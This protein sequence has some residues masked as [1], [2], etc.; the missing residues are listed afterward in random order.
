MDIHVLLDVK[1]YHYNKKLFRHPA[2]N[3]QGLFCS[4]CPT[5]KLKS[6]SWPCHQTT[7]Q[8]AFKQSLPFYLN[9][10]RIKVPSVRNQRSRRRQ[11]NAII[12]RSLR[13]HLRLDGQSRQIKANE[14][15]V[16]FNMN[17]L[18]QLKKIFGLKVLVCI[19][20]LQRVVTDSK[21]LLC[22]K[23]QNISMEVKTI[24]QYEL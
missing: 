18:D 10:G 19:L 8:P 7:C 17:C 16:V 5:K 15:F 9:K 3:Q 20:Q 6:L 11:L 24:L 4:C 23:N 14:T 2:I 21:V 12:S 1:R 22:H 13:P